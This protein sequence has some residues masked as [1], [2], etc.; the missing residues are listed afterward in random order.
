MPPLS[1]TL[2]KAAAELNLSRNLSHL[3][4]EE[5]RTAMGGL[6]A[7]VGRVITPL[8][9]AATG[10]ITA[11]LTATF[12]KVKAVE[13]VLVPSPPLVDAKTDSKCLGI[14]NGRKIFFEPFRHPFVL[15]EEPSHC[16]APIYKEYVPRE[17]HLPIYPVLNL[18]SPEFHC[19]WTTADKYQSTTQAARPPLAPPLVT[20]VNPV[21][22]PSNPNRALKTVRT[23]MQH[24]V[25]PQ[26]LTANHRPMVKGL[27]YAPLPPIN[28]HSSAVKT[29]PE[30]QRPGFCE[31]CYEKYSE[32]E[33]HLQKESHRRLVCNGDFYRAVDRVVSSLER[34]FSRTAHHPASLQGGENTQHSLPD[35][36]PLS[37]AKSVV[38]STVYG[39]AKSF[40]LRNI[41]NQMAHAPSAALPNKVNYQNAAATVV[42]IPMGAAATAAPAA[43]MNII[44][45]GSDSPLYSSPSFKRRRSQRLVARSSRS[46]TTTKFV[47]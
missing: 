22:V 15:L 10:G 45:I 30:R 39:R 14:A 41:T 21:L 36:A 2:R 17:S 26:K 43:D 9:N 31:C 33:V 16:Y 12:T 47:L 19:P 23:L 29:R 1:P 40:P 46:L 4:A 28:A 27:G 3:L 13:S 8:Y 18:H 20:S 6:A 5:K 11:K 37:P 35:D 42:A 34:P 44:E 32:M 38:T 7:R 25:N 24:Q